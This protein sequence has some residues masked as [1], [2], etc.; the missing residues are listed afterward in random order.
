MALHA[1]DG[2]KLNAKACLSSI[3]LTC[4]ATFELTWTL[5]TLKHM[6]RILLPPLLLISAVW[7]YTG[8]EKPSR[9]FIW[10]M[11]CIPVCV[12]SVQH[13]HA[14]GWVFFGHKLKAISARAWEVISHD[15]SKEKCG[16]KNA[17]KQHEFISG[18]VPFCV[19]ESKR[20]VKGG[21]IGQEHNYF[22]DDG[23]LNTTVWQ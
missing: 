9:F 13:S 15:S 19:V 10:Y 5:C 6:V 23:Y 4:H 17:E 22:K 16:E 18:A 8:E 14:D 2:L 12:F 7:R 3:R 11:F 1:S 21:W 20:W